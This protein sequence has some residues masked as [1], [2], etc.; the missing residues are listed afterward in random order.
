MYTFTFDNTS[1]FLLGATIALA[2]YLR[3]SLS[4][5]SPLVHPL[6]LAKQSE[7]SQTRQKN[8]SAIYRNWGTGFGVP[9]PTQPSGNVKI[10]S[11]LVETNPEGLDSKRGRQMYQGMKKVFEGILSD[12][13]DNLIAYIPTEKKVESAPEDNAKSVV[14]LTCLHL[15]TSLSPSLQLLYLPSIDQIPTALS[16]KHHSPPKI[17]FIRYPQLES[18]LSVLAKKGSKSSKPRYG[19]ILA[20]VPLLKSPT[21][22]SP[23]GIVISS[24]WD[25]LDAGDRQLTILEEELN[26]REGGGEERRSRIEAYTK[27]LGKDKTAGARGDV[28]RVV[29]DG[30]RCEVEDV[31]AITYT[32]DGDVLKVTNEVCALPFCRCS[33]TMGSE[34]RN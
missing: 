18:L 30:K 8:Q 2:F 25:V 20:D 5:P 34:R 13:E 21:L 23:S 12:E 10:V 11:D 31:H 7:P 33:M 14:E 4:T 24:Y 3:S 15:A 9:L 16:S 17:F 1:L 32:A 27:I 6:L 26:L 22:P 29:V 19:I 28:L